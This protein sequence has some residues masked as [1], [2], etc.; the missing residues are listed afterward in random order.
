M[1]PKKTQPTLWVQ[2]QQI[3]RW[4]IVKAPSGVITGSAGLFA[5]SFVTM[6]ESAMA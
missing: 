1:L 2:L 4:K 6:P 3:K 5:E